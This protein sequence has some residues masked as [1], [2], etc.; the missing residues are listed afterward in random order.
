MPVFTPWMIGC[1]LI[2]LFVVVPVVQGLFMQY[3][4][5]K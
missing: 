5:D 2:V 1:I 3:W 4:G